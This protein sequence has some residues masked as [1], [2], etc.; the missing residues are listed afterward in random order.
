[1][2]WLNCGVDLNGWLV[3][4]NRKVNYLIFLP[5]EKAIIRIIDCYHVCRNGCV[6]R[7]TGLLDP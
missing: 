6:Y 1:M 4:E 3:S 7:H 5:G 2:K